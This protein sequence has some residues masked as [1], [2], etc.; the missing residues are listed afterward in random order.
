MSEKKFDKATAGEKLS[1]FLTRNRIPVLTIGILLIAAIVVYAVTVTVITKVDEKGLAAV[2][3]I[4]YQLTD[5]S[6]GLSE[7]E[8]EGRRTTAMKQLEKYTNK[9]GII[10][11]RS[12]MLAAEISFERKNYA[13]AKKYWDK[14]AAEGKKSYTAPLA[15]FNAAVC[16]EEMN[17]SATAVADYN[18]AAA[19]KEF[20]MAAHAQFNIGRI[21][22]SQGDYKGASEVYQKLI[23]KTPD[24]TW[25]HLAKSRQIALKTE[26]KVK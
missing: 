23:D 13:D 12:D 10:G 6:S 25:A 3:M 8:L 18:K 15:Y 5:G 16:S 7:T 21:K 22:E 2:D 17:D 4:T 19:V 9:N 14:T 20:G 24:D 26:G 1:G 11:V